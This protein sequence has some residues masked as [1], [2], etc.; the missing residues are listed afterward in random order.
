[1]QPAKKLTPVLLLNHNKSSVQTKTLPQAEETS[2]SPAISTDDNIFIPTSERGRSLGTVALSVRLRNILKIK[3]ILI[4]S[5][6]NG[7]NY[8]DIIKY[9]NCGRKTVI[10]LR[11]LVRELQTGTTNF[12]TRP[13]AVESINVSIFV[14]PISARDFLLSELPL[15]VRLEKV[16]RRQGYNKLSDINGVE[17][18][19]LFYAENCGKKSINEL[20]ELIRRA[21]A[22]EFTPMDVADLPTVLNQIAAS[23]DSGLDKFLPRNR[24]IFEERIGGKIIGPRTLEDIAQE[25]GVTRERVR[26]ITKKSFQTIRRNGGLKLKIALQSL[27][28]ECEQRVCPLTQDL[29]TKWLGHTTTNA[30]D[31]LFYVRVLDTLESSVPAWPVGSTR[32]GGDDPQTPL[33]QSAVENWIQKTG[34][35]PTTAETYDYLRQQP[36]LKNL[37]VATFLAAIRIARK[38]IIDFPEADR[39][40]FRLRRLRISDFARPVLEE[41]NVPLTAEEIVDRAKARY[42][43]SSILVTGRTAGNFLTNEKGIY[44]LEPGAL[45]LRKHFKTRSEIWPAIQKSFSQILRI[46]NRP[47]STTEAIGMPE[48]AAFNIVNAYE[49]AAIIR[50][51]KRFVDL[52]RHL[53]GLEEW[54]IQEREFVK[55]LLPGIFEQANRVLT[56]EQTLEKLTRLRSVSASSIAHHL[57]KHPEIH[58]F[59]FGY[60]G[61]KN[62]GASKRNV[63]L[64]NR[65]TVERAVRRAPKPAS[66]QTLCQ[67]FS[68]EATGEQADLLWKTCAGSAKLRRA[69]DQ[70]G[71]DTLL[72]HKSVSLEQSLANISRVLQRPVPAYELEWELKS[73]YGDLFASIGLKEIE[74]RLAQS[75]WFLRDSAGMFFLDEDFNNEDF[76]PEAIRAAVT[77]SLAESMDI[78][79]CDELIERLELL[80]F[81]L[82]DLSEDMLASILRGAVGLQEVAHQRFRARQ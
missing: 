56:V 48:M 44:L 12:T 68:I 46:Q 49:M 40:Q 74:Q 8:Q 17:I 60:Y 80:G 69:P 37:H 47:V 19:N 41:S 42:G 33:I 5:D 59:G 58:S 77:K 75:E 79:G 43:P 11:E 14:V 35:H 2:S 25:F 62:W 55:N 54:G 29:F 20:Q 61:L 50:E 45:G 38:L 52:G 10:E 30:R 22:G 16:L 71:P 57:Q 67:T 51:D 65:G 78:A 7:L 66:F 36:N 6:L 73:R 39:P 72:L 21:S 64:A 15:S 28:R 24:K 31:S 1:M 76:D 81:E 18:N 63:I 3:N 70:Q 32:E 26:Q 27:A 53:F 23:I 4:L 13:T 9:R 34:H 82:D